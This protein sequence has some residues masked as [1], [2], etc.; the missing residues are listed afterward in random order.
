IDLFVLGSRVPAAFTPKSEIRSWPIIGLMCIASGSLF[1][2]RRASQ[3]LE[4]KQRLKEALDA[5]DIIS[6][7]PE[8]TTNDGTV[9]LPFRSSL[10]S[11]AQETA[12]AVQPISVVYTGLNGRP[13]DAASRPAIGWYGDMYFF[14]HLFQ[15]L[16]QKSVD[17][18]LVFHAPIEP[19]A[20]ASRKE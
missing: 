8:G 18:D 6:I 3:T 12:I 9:L 15:F 4:N 10:F 20:F 19:G 2:D 7:F 13:L 5:G 17:V 14:P 1:I 16:R 11:L